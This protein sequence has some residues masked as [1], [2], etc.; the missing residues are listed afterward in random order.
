MISP[1]LLS[2]LSA[3][4]LFGLVVLFR[5]WGVPEDRFVLA[6]FLFFGMVV[7]MA[8]TFLWPQDLGVYINIFGTSAG[9]WI[10]QTTIRLIGNPNSG[11]AHFTIPWIAR[12]PQVYAW[13]S[14]VIYGVIGISVQY[15]Y[16]Q[17]RK[18][19]KQSRMENPGGG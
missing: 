14:P 18:R 4:T 11:Q 19:E 12:V 8:S 17:I 6:S 15:G 3:G 5:R 13:I 7:G 9:D 16:W 1:L 10:Y 2:L